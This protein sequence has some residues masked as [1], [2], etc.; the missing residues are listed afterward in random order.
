[1]V[2][3]F[4]QSRILPEVKGTIQESVCGLNQRIPKSRTSEQSPHGIQTRIVISGETVGSECRLP[5]PLCRKKPH[6]RDKPIPA[7]RENPCEIHE[8]LKQTRLLEHDMK[9]AQRLLA[10]QAIHQSR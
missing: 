6:A 2:V 5:P 3:G 7:I 4:P 8:S 10:S 1:M 9:M